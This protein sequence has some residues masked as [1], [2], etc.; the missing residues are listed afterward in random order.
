VCGLVLFCTVEGGDCCHPARASRLRSVEIVS[1]RDK[2]L[3][4]EA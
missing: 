4:A 2:P 1:A 3:G